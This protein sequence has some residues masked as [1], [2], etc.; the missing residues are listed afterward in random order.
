MAKYD[1]R[2]N[3]RFTQKENLHKIRYSP[4]YRLEYSITCNYMEFN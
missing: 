1:G 4:P 2:K 3:P